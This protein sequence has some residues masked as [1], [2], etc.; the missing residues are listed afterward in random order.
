MKR[1]ISFALVSAALCGCTNWG[2]ENVPVCKPKETEACV[3]DTGA[4]GV[5]TCTNDG[6]E[7]G[8]CVCVDAG[9]GSGSGSGSG[10]R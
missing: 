1:L 5:R 2:L 9:V 10:V 7:R 3:C 8:A 4:A 6:T